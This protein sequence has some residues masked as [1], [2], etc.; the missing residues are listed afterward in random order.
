MTAPH[1]DQPSRDM[2]TLN[3]A[4]RDLRSAERIASLENI[5]AGLTIRAEQAEY[6]LQQANA[7]RGRLAARLAEIEAQE[8]TMYVLRST[9]DRPKPRAVK[10][11]RYLDVWTG[12]LVTLG[13][14]HLDPLY[15]SPAQAAMPERA[16]PIGYMSPG[17]LYLIRDGEGEGGRYM[18]VRKT[19][20]GLFTLPIYAAAPA[21]AQP[22]RTCGPD[23]CPDSR[24]C[25]KGDAA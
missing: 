18:P 6:R 15:T 24:S 4:L 25:P 17:Q 5:I 16:E 13:I 20:R 8:P 9:K 11:P 14:D 10:H 3:A 1:D 23:G 22:C 21:P 7:E 19:P 2:D 12:E